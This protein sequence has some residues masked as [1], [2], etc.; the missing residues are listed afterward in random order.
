MAILPI[1][2]YEKTGSIEVA[3]WRQGNDEKITSMPVL[4][5]KTFCKV[6]GSSRVDEFE[7]LSELCRILR[8]EIFE[9]ES[10]IK[11]KELQPFSKIIDQLL[12][13]TQ[14]RL[15]YR[16]NVFIQTDILEYEPV[17][18]DLAYPQK[19]EMV[20]DSLMD[21]S[22][23]CIKKLLTSPVANEEKC[24]KFM[25]DNNLALIIEDRDIPYFEPAYCADNN[26][27]VEKNDNYA[28]LN[29]FENTDC[30]LGHRFEN[31]GTY[32]GMYDDLLKQL[33]VTIQKSKNENENF[34]GILA[35]FDN[36][37]SYNGMYDDL[38]KQYAMNY[39][40]S[41]FNELNQIL[42]DCN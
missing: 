35:S 24:L 8:D 27:V 25:K 42:E 22:M 6:F 3:L 41:S 1:I 12:Q 38:I 23:E 10:L 34:D 7:T 33:P 16:T 29:S 37:G 11:F 15:I 31:N 20:I 18:G 21:H 32:N 9:D 28:G 30:L 36:N 13:D 39:N 19:L 5:E 4:M 26:H 40:Q 14:E 17:P 2:H